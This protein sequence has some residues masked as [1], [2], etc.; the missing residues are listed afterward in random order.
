[1]YLLFSS[2][3]II[4]ATLAKPKFQD[5]GPSLTGSYLTWSQTLNGFV[6]TWLFQTADD[7]T[8]DMKIS[9]FRGKK[10]SRDM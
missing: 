1:M 5:S 9:I 7:D 2:L 8:H 10:M 4:I 3:E 6:V